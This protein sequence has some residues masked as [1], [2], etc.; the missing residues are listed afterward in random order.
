MT[1]SASNDVLLYSGFSAFALVIPQFNM[2]LRS[3][4]TTPWPLEP[5]NYLS[6]MEFEMMFRPDSENGVLLYSYD[7][8]SKDFLS[9]NMV[10]GYVEFRF[11]CGSGTAVIR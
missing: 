7:T 2:S 6:F 8:D 3:F 11:D 4:A 1:S 5:Q 9:I 10:A